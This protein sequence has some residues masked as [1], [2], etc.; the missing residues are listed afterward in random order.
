[1]AGHPQGDPQWAGNA[2][3]VSGGDSWDGDPTKVEPSAGRK[4]E[5][6]EPTQ[7]PPAEFFNW[8]QNNVGNFLEWLR[9]T[10]VKNWD[11]VDVG[12]TGGLRCADYDESTRTLIVSG[13]SGNVDTRR[14]LD[15]GLSWVAPGTPPAAVQ[16]NDLASDGAGTWVACRDDLADV[17]ESS[18]D[19]DTWTARVMSGAGTAAR[20]VWEP[21]SA[22]FV[23]LA[24]PEIWT[25]P[26]G[27]TWTLRHTQGGVVYNRIAVGGG[28]AVATWLAGTDGHSHSADMITWTDVAA[29]PAGDSYA[30]VAYSAGADLWM[31]VGND[32][33]ET[34]PLVLTSS[35][36]G[37]TFTQGPTGGLPD[38]AFFG[39]VASDDGEMWV[40]HEA[41]DGNVYASSDRGLTWTHLNAAGGIRGLFDSAGPPTL[42]EI[43]F[44]AR[45]FM[46][47]NEE[48]RLWRTTAL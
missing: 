34:S 12:A 7:K 31:I 35:D 18:D 2:T 41:T 9:F 46:V 36:G 32:A 20:V 42:L 16:I 47:P 21:T 44:R 6:W 1:M 26:D 45:R 43:K 38:P 19:G 30:D 4:A 39:R 29:S 25:S 37:I 15:G 22:L 27:I 48:G 10:Q 3:F 14:S 13:D 23:A 17:F 8:W 11:L 24:G 33:S 5:G 40:V 28:R